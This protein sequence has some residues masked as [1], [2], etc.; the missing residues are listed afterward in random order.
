MEKSNEKSV[1][2]L[3]KETLRIYWMHSKKYPGMVLLSIFGALLTI[4]ADVVAPIIYK[5][6]FDLLTVSQKN[7]TVVSNI[8]QKMYLMMGVAFASWIGGRIC[9]YGVS[10][11]EILVMADL[12]NYCFEYLHRHSHQF[13]TGNFSGSLVKRVNRF[14]SG[15]EVIA[16]QCIL[17]LGQVAIR[18]LLIIVVIFW[19]N[20]LIGFM[21]LLWAFLFIIFNFFFAKWKLKFDI[22]RA[23]LDTKT[24][25][26]LSDTIANNINIKLF[27]GLHR[28]SASFK[29][30]T[31]RLASARYRSW[32]MGEYSDAV[33]GVSIRVLE[34]VMLASAINY[35]LN[36]SITVGGII[37]LRSYMWQLA[38]RIREIGQ[39]V[40]KIY[41][42]MADS[43]EMTEILVKPHEIL[44]SENAKRLVVKNGKVEFKNVGFNY[45]DPRYPIFQN[46]NLKIRKNSRVG[47]V[48]TSGGGKSTLIKLLTRLYDLNSGSILIDG[49][50]IRE[51][52]QS[53]L[54]ENIAVVPQDPVLFHRTL[55][56]NIRYSRPGATD[57]EVIRAS[58]LAHCHEFISNSPSGYNTFV[59]ER[60]LKLSGGE[61]QRVAIARAILMNPKII[62]FDEATSALDSESEKLIQDA[63]SKLM[64]GRTVIAIA[65]RLSTISKM[66]N[67]VVISQ[68][69]IIEEGK[70]ES[71]IASGGHY[72]KLWSLQ[73]GGDKIIS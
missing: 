63:M 24:T 14:T 33:Q 25:A 46:F 30:I 42:A 16:D 67:I 4:F 19:Q 59:G 9:I 1:Y 8:W 37:M 61:R 5:D 29:E 56:E 72:S 68:G 39:S 43:N 2:S 48:G 21:F 6:F 70:H 49:Q 58:K 38:D 3:N 52:T 73:Y 28:E 26:V 36:G 17:Q 40:R 51:V 45:G 62:V 10:K 44:D 27:S 13:F 23:E 31:S 64:E 20:T 12:P 57:E 11:F 71:L 69:R 32:R 53:S 7:N 15:F 34:F 50:D 41:E 54:N 55:M 65:H 66:D 22:Y 35:W 60:G 18:I 47:I